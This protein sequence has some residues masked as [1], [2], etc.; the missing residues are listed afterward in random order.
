MEAK[1]EE[2]NRFRDYEAS[3]IESSKL[4]SKA[5]HEQVDLAEDLQLRLHRAEEEYMG[6]AF[7]QSGTAASYAITRYTYRVKV[8]GY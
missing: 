1:E 5:F 6:L 7:P 2:L 3:V 8:R 4:K